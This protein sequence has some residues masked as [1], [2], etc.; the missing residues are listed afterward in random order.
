MHELQLAQVAERVSQAI[1]DEDLDLAGNLLW[2]AIDQKSDVGPL[3][4]YAGI[5]LSM[6]GLQAA[7]LLMFEK[8]Q[9]LEPHPANFSNIGGVLRQ[10]GR[11]EEARQYLKMGLDRGAEPSDIL[12][13]LCGSYVNEGD[14]FTGIEYGEEALRRRPNHLA[15]MFNLSLLHLEAG[16]FARGF[17]LYAEGQ[18]KN[19]IEKTYDPDPPLLTPELHE[20]LRGKG[21]K[22]IVYGEQ[23]IGDE[24]LFATILRDLREDYEVIFDCH[25]RLHSMHKHASWAAD[26]K[27]RAMRY[28]ITLHPTRKIEFAHQGWATEADAKLPIGNLGRFYRR[29]REAWTW[30]GPVYGGDPHE[31]REM[32]KTLEE[33]AQGRK[34]IGLALRGGTMSTA[35]TYRMLPPPALDELFKDDR[36]LF[37]G[38]DYEDMTKTGDWITQTYGPGRFVWYP[39]VCWAWD[40]SH[41]AS[42]IAATD[43]VVTV[44]QSVAHLSAAMGHPTHVLVPSKP[45][46]RYGISGEEWFLYRHKN[47]VLARQ[48]GSDWAPASRRV[49]ELLRARF[50]Q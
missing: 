42:L 2:P 29:S 50:E 47:A 1:Q 35:R 16:N 23:G 27:R 30:H 34:L 18:H 38:L 19:R 22:V 28:P 13:N 24:I 40:Y 20:E 32:R 14:P 6:R 10:M 36:Y 3:Y 49:A 8:S 15:A 39:S 33:V 44:C 31:K 4:F 48:Q 45:A 12:G 46:W 25:P 7:A 21:K 41:V 37:V 11:V 5:L 9:Q 43:A 26:W 17:D